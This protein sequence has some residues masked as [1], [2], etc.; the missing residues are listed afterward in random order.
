MRRLPAGS[1][2][3][4][5]DRL[6]ARINSELRAIN[7]ELAT[8]SLAEYTKQGWAWVDPAPYRHNWHIEAISDHLQGV[9]RRQIPRLVVNMPPRRMKS[10]S[11]NV[12][13]PS[14]V[15]AQDPDPLDEGHAM[16]VRPGTWMG[17]GVRF[18]SASYALRL[19]I[20]DNVKCRRLLESSWYQ[21]NWPGRVTFA[22]DQ[23][24]KS[25]Y[26]NQQGGARYAT[27]VDAAV[28][29]E[30]GDIII[31]DDPINV[32]DADSETVREGV[33]EWFAESM[34][35]R[36][37]D[38]KTGA[39]II[40]MQRVHERDLTGYVLAK[41]MG[42]DHLCLPEKYEPDHPFP[43]RSS[44]GFKDPRTQPGELL[45]PERFGEAEYEK[46]ALSL[47]A[48]ATAGQLQQR[49]APR[50]GGLF[51]RAW[52]EIVPAAPAKAKRVRRWDLA[53]TVEKPGAD[54]DWTVGVKLALDE[55]GIFYVEHVRRFR[56]DPHTVETTIK[57]TATQ[58]G[59]AVRIV[60]PQDPGAAGKSQARYLVRQLRGFSAS[61]KL[62]SGSKVV[63]ADPVAAQAA[64]G[65]IK[66]VADKEGD[67]WIETFL[68]EL[69]T[70]PNGSHDDQV[71]GL[72]GAFDDLVNGPGKILVTPIQGGY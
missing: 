35:T 59:K 38:A 44:I 9:A 7:R 49:P 61:Y 32:R 57:N 19:A 15:W 67:R 2:P 48:Y 41:E 12:M 17:P 23:N 68:D 52:F 30:G 3:T 51:K 8:R 71:D 58:D 22:P 1:I 10:L 34:P 70:F 65:N 26:E 14:W 27:G 66:L 60:V 63:R 47:G 33:L 64:A 5:E 31:I 50:E 16:N 39:F 4:D 36:L 28:T 56:G 55:D 40:V 54:P 43:S 72:T 20:R 13:F 11:I 18:L 24:T 53:A 42:W 46:L 6:R 29:G 21:E 45:W 69:S 37:N 62:E 25:F